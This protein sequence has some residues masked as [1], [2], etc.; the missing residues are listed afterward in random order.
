[1]QRYY[2]E[3]WSRMKQRMKD[4]LVSIRAKD[5]K[6]S[7][8]PLS[9]ITTAVVWINTLTI[10]ITI[11]G[12]KFKCIST[13]T[14]IQVFARPLIFITYSPIEPLQI[15][16]FRP[17]EMLLTNHSFHSRQSPTCTQT[18]RP[19]LSKS[20]LVDGQQFRAPTMLYDAA[21]RCN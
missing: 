12:I 15:S 14:I 17:I 10:S 5:N 1:M 21:D 2:L 9:Q 16:E 19:L 13:N 6:N 11:L 20:L 4:L 3:N 7:A 18:G 8:Q